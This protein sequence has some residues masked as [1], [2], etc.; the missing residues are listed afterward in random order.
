MHDGKEVG[1]EEEPG[2]AVLVTFV[3]VPAGQASGLLLPTGQYD[4]S[5]QTV[6]WSDSM[7]DVEVVYVPA[8]QG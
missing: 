2:A 3:Y 1:N 6:H 4:P 5:G 7:R 8:G